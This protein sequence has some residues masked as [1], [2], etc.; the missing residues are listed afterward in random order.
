MPNQNKN[1]KQEHLDSRI[2]T[3]IFFDI[4]EIADHTIDLPHMLP[5]EEDFIKHM[6]RLQV[7]RTD[8]IIC[9]DNVG[10]FSSPRVA[11]TMRFFGAEKVRILNGG[12]KKWVAE[13]RKT[14][15]GPSSSDHLEKGGDYKYKVV[16][17]ENVVRNLKDMHNMVYYVVNNVLTTQIV[18]ARSAAR[19]NGEV[20]E[21][22]K[23]LRRGKI[24]GSKNVFF[25]DLVD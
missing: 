23:G 1:P 9:Y 19:F 24:S 10:I 5:S 21:P 22:R 13:K 8:N 11:W 3:S 20:D 12:F 14:E 18:D 6:E 2:P 7:R 25:N 15:S 17:E 4:D 16:D